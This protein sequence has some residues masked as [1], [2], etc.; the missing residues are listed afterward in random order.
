MMIAGKGPL[1]FGLRTAA[2][3]YTPSLALIQVC[4]TG[5]SV[6]LTT[7]TYFRSGSAS[8]LPAWRVI[9][10]WT[11]AA[12]PAS[13]R[14]ARERLTMLLS[15]LL[16]DFIETAHELRGGHDGSAWRGFVPGTRVL[17]IF[18]RK[19]DRNARGDITPERLGTLTRK[20]RHIVVR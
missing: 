19:F 12:H 13:N 17:A 5:E 15:R 9:S 8:L 2:A 10:A 1:P 6:S 16:R 14:Q 4:M 7:W 18:E 20:R 3:M 11:I